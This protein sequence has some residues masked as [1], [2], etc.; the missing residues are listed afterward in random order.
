MQKTTY[1]VSSLLLLFIIVISVI[2]YKSDDTIIQQ[3]EETAR[4][5]FFHEDVP[6][7]NYQ[8]EF[9]SFYLPANMEVEEVDANN[10][11]LQSGDQTFLVFY[12]TL[13]D[14]N[15]TLNYNAAQNDEAVLLESFSDEEKFGYI[16]LLPSDENHD[17]YEI[18]I[19]VGGVKITTF[20]Q[21]S[22]IIVETENLM[23]T[24]LSLAQ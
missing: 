21:K 5:T 23:K 22:E 19:G 2:S 10:A 8:G 13:E 4:D 14:R 17:V 16:R 15:S 11:I 20:S 6:T 7:E 12:N 1:L 3:A 24:A 9:F 18:Q